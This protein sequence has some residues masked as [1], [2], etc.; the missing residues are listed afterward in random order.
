[1]NWLKSS[2]C[3]AVLMS[4]LISASQAQGTV[5]MKKFTCAQLLSGSGNA[6]EAAI[7]LSGYYNGLRKNTVL[8]LDQFKKNAEAVVAEC[9]ANPKK[10][11][12]QIGNTMLSA[13]KKKK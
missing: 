11:V 5:D 3:V 7:W 10:T 12:M 13:G 8:N 9:G 6:V 2:V 1:M 4:I